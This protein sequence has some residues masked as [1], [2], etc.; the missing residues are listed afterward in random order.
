MKSP[1]SSVTFLFSGP[2]SALLHGTPRDDVVTMGDIR[3]HKSTGLHKDNL[4]SKL[5]ST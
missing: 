1:S 2:F 5:C 3:Y 4:F